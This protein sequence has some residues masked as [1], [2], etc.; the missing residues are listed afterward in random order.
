MRV[1]LDEAA[2]AF[3]LNEVPV[4]AVVVRDEAVLGR[5]HNL[6][7]SLRDPTAHAEIVA[8][9]AACDAA[10]NAKL[11]KAVMYVTLEPCAMCAGALVLSRIST[12]VFGAADPKGGSC[13]TLR[14]IVRDRRLNHRIDVVYG[15]EAEACG[16]LLT[17]FFAQKRSR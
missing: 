15:V 2:K 3:E 12:L 6:V 17:E 13:G 4:G 14:N 8:I 16:G 11:D 10:S 1:A 7:E 9:G 5:G